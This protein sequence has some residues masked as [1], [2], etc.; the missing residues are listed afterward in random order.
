MSIDQYAPHIQR[1]VPPTSDA[2]AVTIRLATM[3]DIPRLAT[4]FDAYR[5]FY[6]LASA[7]R[8]AGEFLAARLSA[9]E[10]I[11]LLGVR[12]TNQEIVGFAQL[13]LGFSSLSLGAVIVL[14]D[15]FVVPSARRHGV[16]GRLVDAAI[17]HARQC[18]ALR[19]ELETHPDNAPA[20]QLYREKGFVVS[21]EFVHMNLSMR[22]P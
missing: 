14:N 17:E 6:G 1:A 10:S 9:G 19:I 22:S 12:R 20:M 3:T 2:T 8:A 16:G 21:D 7:H 5:V 11:I 13:F 18:G 15:L 4:L